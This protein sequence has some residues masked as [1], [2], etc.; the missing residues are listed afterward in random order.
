MTKWNKDNIGSQ[1]GKVIIITGGGSGIGLAAAAALA[2]RGAEVILAVRNI[3]KG[4][5][6]AA[7]I[8]NTGPAV[9]VNVMHLDLGDLSSVS[10]FATQ[11]A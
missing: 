6:A 2:S 5:R 10:V 8:N 7:Q 11:F 1:E 3:Q 9:R 4:N